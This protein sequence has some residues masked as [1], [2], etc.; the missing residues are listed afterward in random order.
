MITNS[1]GFGVGLG[2]GAGRGLGVG[3]GFG[4]MPLGLVQ[5]AVVR[6]PVSNPVPGK[7]RK[8]QNVLATSFQCSRPFC[9]SSSTIPSR[10]SSLTP[11]TVDSVPSVK[12]LGY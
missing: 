7:A 11:D 12:E 1:N 10:P 3:W 4:G 8:K 2:F 9:G 5:L 6:G